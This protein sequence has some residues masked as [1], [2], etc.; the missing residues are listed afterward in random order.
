M[1][2]SII[3]AAVL[4]TIALA[5]TTP[6]LALEPASRF[7]ITFRP[8][9]GKALLAAAE[10]VDRMA[11]DSGL[12]LHYV[13]PMSMGAHVAQLQV[14]VSR[15]QAEGIAA[16][17]RQRPDIASID[18]D[19]VLHPAFIPNDEF[20]TAQRY[21]DDTVTG[22]SA[23]TAWDVTRGSPTTVV[24]VIDTGVLPHAGMIGRILPGY[25]FVSD[26][27]R[28]NDGDGRDPDASD[29]GD[30]V[31]QADINGPLAG[32]GCSVE[33]S[34]WHGT[35]VAG[36]IVANTNDGVWTAG[37]DWYA[38][39][40]PV[41]VLGKCGGFFSDIID[42]MAW[43]GG[44]AVPGVPPN[45][46]PAHVLNLSLGGD[47]KCPS[48]AQAVINVLLA[49]GAVKA[50][51]A[52]AG[53]DADD[54]V[55]HT[56]A[57][58]TGVIAVASTSSTGRRAVY[59]NYG[60]GIALAAPGGQYGSGGFVD[61]VYALSNAGTTAPTVDAPANRYGGTSFAAPMVSGVAALI[62]GVA[63]GITPGQMRDVLVSTA[64]PFLGSSTCDTTICGSGLVDAHAAVVAAQAFAGP[65]TLTVIEYYNASLDHYFI[66]Y[67]PVEQANLDAGNTPT[68]WTRTGYAF[69]AYAAPQANTSPV[70]RF[71]IPPELGDSHF[72]GRGTVE[73][74]QTRQKNPTFVLE[75]PAFMQMVLPSGG[76]CAAGT[77]P[78]YR[79]FDNR[80][81]ANHR[82]MTDRA[83]RDQMVAKGWIAE[84][85]GPDL[86]VMCGAP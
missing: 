65:A 70:C 77:Q 22:I 9:A 59:S 49:N 8:D 71:Y 14:P 51:V 10:H 73:C 26:V 1:R 45:P 3:V 36:I 64:K 42:G 53:N 80:K 12:A 79:V 27:T 68:R 47:G 62:R 48:S 61:G 60:A 86:V 44:L 17:L 78:V 20:Y 66:T 7:I 76:T 31:T 37:I 15:S 4:A 84:G 82:Y 40:L 23:T 28:A 39:V 19:L 32:G 55:N 29:P 21:L 16:M 81:D 18:V 52:A 34:S 85:D 46:T 5:G 6:S 74:D 35:S 2:A 30:W 43:A 69:N 83:V 41:R 63:P 33:D 57:N 50:V 72:F 67:S 54:V 38:K 25:D 13:R 11:S 56:P 58:C 75:D 24:A